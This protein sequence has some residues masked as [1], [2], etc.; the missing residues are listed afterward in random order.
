MNGQELIRALHE[1]QAVYGTLITCP[2]PKWVDVVAGLGLDYVF[3]DQEHIPLDRETAAWMCQAYA[4]RGLAPLLRIPNP[5]PDLACVALDGGAAGVIAPYVETADQVRALR[6]AVK[7]RPLKGERLA[8]ILAGQDEREPELKTYQDDYNAGHVLIVNIESQPAI[9]NL[10]TILAVPDLDAVLIGPHDLSTNL[11]V[12]EQYFHPRF[13]A[14]VET[15]I[16][17]ARAQNIG[18]GIHTIYAKG[19]DQEVRWIKRGLNLVLHLA[20]IMAFSAKMSEDL[21]AIKMALGTQ[22][23]VSDQENINI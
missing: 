21:R 22:E 19:L 3:I 8:Q 5:D 7:L 15:I 23:T 17:K 16:D 20:D 1:G 11:G 4:G 6:G 9:D 14:A 18:V 12:P 2:S 13:E 10:D